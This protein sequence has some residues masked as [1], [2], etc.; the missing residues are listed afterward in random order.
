MNF[1]FLLSQFHAVFKKLKEKASL[2]V[3]NNQKTSFQ[4]VFIIKIEILMSKLNIWVIG[5]VQMKISFP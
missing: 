3:R 5:F 2:I 1:S 4:N